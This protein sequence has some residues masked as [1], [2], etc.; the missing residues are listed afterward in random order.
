MDFYKRKAKEAD[1]EEAILVGANV[2]ISVVN[3]LNLFCVA[4]GTSKSSIIRPLVEDWVTDAKEKF[5]EK[6]LCNI[7]GDRGYDAWINRK[8]RGM[9]FVA[10]LQMQRRELKRKGLSEEIIEKIIQ[11]VKDGKNSER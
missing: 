8:R 7:A 3:F 10:C 2:P 5:T 1:T 9:T 6:Q 4:D 11:R